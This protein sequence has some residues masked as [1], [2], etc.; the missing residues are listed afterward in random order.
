MI[1]YVLFHETNTSRGHT[2]DSDGFV[3]G[4]YATEAAAKA[5]ELEARREASEKGLSVWNEDGSVED[6][7]ND[8]HVEAHQVIEEQS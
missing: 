3:E 8:W 5:A 4:V 2:D 1:V 7:A 6:W